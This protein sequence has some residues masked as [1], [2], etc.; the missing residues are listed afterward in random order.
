VQEDDAT[1]RQEMFK[2]T[3][4]KME[5]STENRMQKVDQIQKKVQMLGLLLTFTFTFTLFGASCLAL[6]ILYFRVLYL[7]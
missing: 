4:K 7:V 3:L 2:K 1:K 6:L 5:G